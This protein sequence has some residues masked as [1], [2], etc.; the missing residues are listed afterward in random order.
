VT[1]G[2]FIGRLAASASAQGSYPAQGSDPAEATKNA[3]TITQ[4]AA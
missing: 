3:M 1:D 4:P 2:T